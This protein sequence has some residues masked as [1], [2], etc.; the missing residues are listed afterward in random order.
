MSK[1]NKEG[2]ETRAIHAGQKADP[3]TGAVMM[4]IYTSST[5]EQESPGVHK[6]FDYSRSINPTRKAFEECIASLEN[7]EVGFGFSSGV[8]AIS[9]CVELLSPGDHVI[10][11][12]DLYGGTVRLFNEIKTISQ[13]IEVTY[14]DMTDMQNVLEAKTDK[15]KMIFVETPTNP[16]LRVVDLSAIADFAKAENILSVCDNTFAS[17]Y[18]QQPLNHGIDIVLHSA[19]KYLGGH[20]D[21]IAGALVIGKKDDA[22]VSKMA[23][24]VNSLGP[25]TGAFD[26]YL[27]LRSLKTLAVR[28]ERHSENAMAIAKHFESHKDISE[29]IYPGL[30]NHPQHDLASKQMNGFGG[31]ISMNIKGGL[32]KSKSFLE[33]TKIFALAES[34]GGVESLIEH[35]ALMTHASLP[36]DRREMIGISDGLVRLSVGLESLD[37]LIEDIEQALK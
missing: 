15:T 18:V 23:N 14:V 29:V 2:F 8:A 28:M 30:A 35:P 26:S 10:A 22:L 19:T 7:G 6:G 25:I 33:R 17:P 32:E 9:A 34:L 24:I 4:P 12:N 13:G 16:L 11:M 21:L 37:D 3:T 27:I 36:K 5:Y 1:K 20:S 31:I